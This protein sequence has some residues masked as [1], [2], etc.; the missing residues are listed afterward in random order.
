MISDTEEDRD[1]QELATALMQMY[2]KRVQGSFLEN[3]GSAISWNY[4]LV[5]A[6]QVA[7]QM[8]M[9]LQTFL[10]PEL[11]E[12]LLRGYPVATAVGK[13]YV[14][15]KRIDIDKGVAVRRTLNDM[16]AQIGPVDFILCL[17]DDR[18]DEDMFE[19]VEEWAKQIIRKREDDELN[20]DLDVPELTPTQAFLRQKSNSAMDAQFGR[21]TSICAA[22]RTEGDENPTM[23]KRNSLTIEDKEL[24]GDQSSSMYYT[25]TVGRKPSKARYYVKDTEEVS[26]L[27]HK[28]AV[29]TT[30]AKLSRFSSMP[31]LVDMG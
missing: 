23:K 2:C 27:L 14:E 8:A 3:K 12:G 9:E 18:S 15:V 30:K 24:Y 4:G 20:D 5:S 22:A 10:D 6:P 31:S 26:E 17:G 19:V 7:Q 29:A 1:W 28:F 16:E 11:E 25:A 21:Q 13:G